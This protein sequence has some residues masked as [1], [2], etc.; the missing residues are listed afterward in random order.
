MSPFVDFRHRRFHSQKRR[1]NVLFI[2]KNKTEFSYIR[3]IERHRMGRSN[4]S[5]PLII[6][7]VLGRWFFVIFLVFSFGYFSSLC[8]LR[9]YSFMYQFV[10]IWLLLF[11]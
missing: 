3:R 2:Q 1:E 9:R 10:E 7:F 8:S 4:F 6:I 11:S 5:S